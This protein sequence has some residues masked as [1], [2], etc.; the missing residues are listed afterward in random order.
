MRKLNFLLT[1]ASAVLLLLISSTNAQTV[2]TTLIEMYG[3]DGF[4][5]NNEVSD[6]PTSISNW[7]QGANMPHARY[8]AGSVM[9]TRSDTSW[10]YVFGGDTTGSGVATSTCLRYNLETDTWEY[11]APLPEPI[12]VNA[13]AKLGDK[14]YSIGGF[15]APFPSPAISSFYEYDVNTNTW[16]QLPDLPDPLF[17][18]GAEGFED[19]LIYIFGGIQDNVSDGDL[20]RF[21]VVLYNRVSNSFREATP[22]PNATASF[23]HVRISASFY[24]TGG[25]KS[26]TELWNVQ[27][28]GEVDP[29]EKANIN[30]TLRANYPLSVYAAYNYPIENNEEHCVLGGSTTTGFMP[31]N[32]GFRYN[33]PQNNFMMKQPLPIN[34]MASSGGYTK[35]LERAPDGEIIQRVVLAGGI[36]NGPALTNQTWIFTD[37]VNVSGL[38][39][40]T[41]DVPRDYLLMQNYPNPFNPSTTINFSIPEASFVSLIV[42][43]SLGE[44]VTILVSKELNAGDYKYDWNAAG[45]TSGIYFYRIQAGSFIETKKMILLK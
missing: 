31:N 9:Y 32:Q 35:S 30:W 38:S 29:V 12:R 18:A 41:N 14:L 11:I 3:K 27:M 10:L 26:T 25:L 7:I 24:I 4:T 8:Y 28:E 33:I 43:N 6:Q 16:T 5:I 22:M 34:L 21:N 23:G 45:L 1:V 17:F 15:N 39:E 40:I 37:T 42:F 2:P 19:S 44:K 13:A 20:W 36:T